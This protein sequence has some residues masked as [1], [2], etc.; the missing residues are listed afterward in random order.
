MQA[1]LNFKHKKAD[2]IRQ[3]EMSANLPIKGN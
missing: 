2:I 1:T 3:D